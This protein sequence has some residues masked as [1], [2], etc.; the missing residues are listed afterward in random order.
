MKYSTQK[1]VMLEVAIVKLCTQQMEKDYESLIDRLNLLEHKMED[2]I[3]MAAPV[4]MPGM[5]APEPVKKKEL[6]KAVAEDVKKALREWKNFLNQIDN[7]LLQTFLR[8]GKATVEEN[9]DFV[10]VFDSHD[11]KQQTAYDSLKGREEEI[12]GMLSEYMEVD[13]PVKFVL[14]NSGVDSSR[15]YP[16]AIAHFAQEAD[17]KLEVEDF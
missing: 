8:S 9:G 11:M 5:A 4:A 10:V 17:I 7:G 14:N 12:S 2:G 6:P 16:D 13:I 15:I 3:P 1:R